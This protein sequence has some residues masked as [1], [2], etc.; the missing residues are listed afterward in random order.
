MNSRK[1]IYKSIL[2]E[3]DSMRMEARRTLDKKKTYIHEQSPQIKDIERELALTGA[4]VARLIA[5]APDK[6][7]EFLQQL[8][9]ENKKLMDRKHALLE[10]LGL[11]P[12][13]LDM[14]YKCGTCEDTGYVGNEL[15]TCFKHRL[16]RSAYNQSNIKRT[17]QWENFSTFNFDYFN[18]ENVPDEMKSPYDNMSSNYQHAVEFVKSF[19][20]QQNMLYYGQ[21]G[22]GKTF[23]TNCVA[24]AILDRGFLVL[25]FTAFELF[26]LLERYKFHHHE[27]MEEGFKNIFECD[28]LIIDDLGSEMNT[29]FTSSELFNCINTRIL[30]QRSTIISTNLSIRDIQD[31]YSDRISSRIIGH[32]E[33]FKFYGGDIRIQKK[34]QP[35]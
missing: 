34:L 29:S 3:Y 2:K 8:K 24:K 27:D 15:C 33:L 23:L 4:R 16:V 10:E 6:Q 12:H 1:D 30:E 25:Y 9:Q 19:P 20:N 31:H 35:K 26:N 18:K 11:D 21:A 7:E 22:T 14:Q 32:Y 13:Y 28:L 17:L 5:Q